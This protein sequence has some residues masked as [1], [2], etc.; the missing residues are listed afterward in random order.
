MKI[1]V[2]ST[3]IIDPSNPSIHGKT[4]DIL[5]DNGIISEIEDSITAGD[6]KHVIEHQGLHC[7]IGW[8]DGRVNFQDPGLEYKEDLNSGAEAATKGGFTHVAISPDTTP[9]LHNKSQLEY[10]TRRNDFSGLQLLPMST[11][12][13]NLKGE[14]LAELYD[15]QNNGAIAFSDCTKKLSTGILYRAL[16]YTKNFKR[17]VISFPMD[18][19]LAGG[20]MVNEGLASV[21]TGLKAVPN[22]A[23]VLIVK[24]DLDLLRYTA[25]KLHFTGISTKESVELIREAKREGLNITADVYAANVLYNEERVLGFDSNYKVFPPLR[26]EEDR[27]AI[28]QGLKDGTIDFICSNHSP[29]DKENKDLEFDLANYGTIGTQ[30]LFSELL[31]AGFSL[32]EITEYIGTRVYKAFGE[33]IPEIKIGHDANLTLFNPNLNWEFNDDSNASKSRNSAILGEILSGKAIATINNGVL[34]LLEE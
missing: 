22:V 1:L 5:I 16:L 15:L 20:G 7:S 18:Y 26:T 11:L 28:I 2:K 4:K 30:T 3:T 12:T 9:T 24:R 34:S 21:K 10:I 23:E 17:K 25:S 29:E 8:F 27:Q 32:E 13:D 33:G 6:I 19:A 14:N 31:G